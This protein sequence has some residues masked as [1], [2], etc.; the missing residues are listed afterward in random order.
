MQAGQADTMLFSL[1]IQAHV[2]PGKN[3]TGLE[4]KLF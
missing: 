4:Q 3:K 2:F 1:F